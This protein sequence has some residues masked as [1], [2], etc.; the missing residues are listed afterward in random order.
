MS[1]GPPS[2]HH[3]EDPLTFSYPMHAAIC[4]MHSAALPAAEAFP[5]AHAAEPSSTCGSSS[6]AG[7]CFSPW[8]S[9]APTGCH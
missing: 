5:K 8:V 4:S 1:Q 3:P 6:P 9:L 7:G 2:Q